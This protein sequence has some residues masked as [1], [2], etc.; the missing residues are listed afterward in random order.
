M[1]NLTN[2]IDDCLGIATSRGLSPTKPIVI[3]IIS[4]TSGERA[5]IVCAYTEPHTLVLPFNVTWIDSDP[6]SSDYKDAFKRTAKTPVGSMQHTWEQ[7]LAFDDIFNP[8][9]YYDGDDL[10]QVQSQEADIKTAVDHSKETVLTSDPHQARF[11]TDIRIS[12]L[13]A[14]LQEAVNKNNENYRLIQE[15]ILG[16]RTANEKITQLESGGGGST[17]SKIHYEETAKASWT[18]THNFGTEDIICQIYD[19]TETPILPTTMT[20]IDDNA[21]EIQFEAPIAGKAILIGLE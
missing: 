5:K 19:D 8:A 16:L 6:A 4:P 12:A 18:I 14:S 3:S 9:Q 11:Y 13:T 17:L 20:A 15:L 1:A 7:V 21:W 10:P 2:L